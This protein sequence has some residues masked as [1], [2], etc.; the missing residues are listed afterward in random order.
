MPVFPEISLPEKSLPGKTFRRSVLPKRSMSDAS[1][2]LLRQVGT[3]PL[4]AEKGITKKDNS[5]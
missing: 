5:G 2:P 1:N 3:I 4:K